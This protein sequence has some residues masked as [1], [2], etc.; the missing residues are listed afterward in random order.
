MVV[1]HSG[2]QG[3]HVIIGGWFRCEGNPNSVYGAHPMEHGL[4]LPVASEVA[5][6]RREPRYESP[7][8]R[9]SV[10]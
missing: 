4:A 9:Q 1:C 8:W 6:S 7:L 10:G 3:D 5:D 2:N